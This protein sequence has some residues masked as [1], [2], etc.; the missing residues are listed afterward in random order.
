MADQQHKIVAASDLQEINSSFP[1]RGESSFLN[2][3]LDSRLH[4]K[5][6]SIKSA[7]CLFSDC[8]PQA[9]KHFLP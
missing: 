4:G 1:R 2:G 3:R 5:D 6:E 8:K 7:F 9:V